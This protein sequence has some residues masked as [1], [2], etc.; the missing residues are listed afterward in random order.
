MRSQFESLYHQMVQDHTP[1]V[2]RYL[3]RWGFSPSEAEEATQE[4]YLQ[5]WKS[6]GSFRKEQSARAWLL[7]IAR[8]VAW[9]Y[10]QSRVYQ[11]E[12]SGFQSEE[13]LAMI[14][15]KES[16]LGPDQYDEI[17]LTLQVLASLSDNHQEVLHLRYLQELSEREIADV[18]QI[19]QNTVHSRLRVARKSYK[20]AY[21][22]FTSDLPP[23]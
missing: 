13:I 16:A 1:S 22:T 5:A 12:R 8:R 9:R 21:S 17:K 3:L 6:I 7:S 18:L 2:Y 10:T 11:H 14:D 23:G 4:S 15:K 20:A 19:P